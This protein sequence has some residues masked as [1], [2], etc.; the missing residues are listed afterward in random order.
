LPIPLSPRRAGIVLL[1][2]LPIGRAIANGLYNEPIAGGIRLG[3][4]TTVPD[5]ARLLSNGGCDEYEEF[6]D[7]GDGGD[8][9]DNG[10]SRLPSPLLTYNAIH[11][12]Y[13]TATP[14]PNDHANE[15]RAMK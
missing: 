10:A 6:G 11:I 5:A 2:G 1:F 4:A 9:G 14:H 8:N 12:R 13:N 15:T 7:A 3:D